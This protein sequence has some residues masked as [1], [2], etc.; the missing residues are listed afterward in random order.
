MWKEYFVYTFTTNLP[1]GTGAAFTNTSIRIDS[2]ADFEFHKTTYIATNDRIKLRYKDDSAGRYLTRSEVD[3]KTIAGRN[4]LAMGLS[5]SFIPFVWPRPYIISAG[6]NFSLEASDYSGVANTLRLAFHGAKIRQGDA[7]WDKN[8]RALVPFVYPITGTPITVAANSTVSARIEIDIDSH[9]LV[10]KV[11]AIRTGEALINITDGAR[12][13]EWGNVAVHIDNV[14]G[15]GALPNILSANRFIP[16]G[17]V[18]TLNIQDLS[19]L[20][21]IIELNLIG[22]K[23]YV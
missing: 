16:R 2:D 1:A 5:N 15:N 17:S 6:A 10:Q 22:V 23:L 19:G 14:A 9:F 18:V 21:N 3:I 8:F 7:P 11:V 13:R 12:G 20:A 4:T